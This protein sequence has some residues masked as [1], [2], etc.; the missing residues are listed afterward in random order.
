MTWPSSEPY[1]KRRRL[2][3]S[4]YLGKRTSTSPPTNELRTSSG[5]Q[6]LHYQRHG[7]TQTNKST[8]VGRRGLV[9]RS[10]PLDHLSLVPEGHPE[11]ANEHWMTSSMPNAHT[12]RIC[13]TPSETVEISST[14]L[15]MANPSN[16]YHLPHHEE[17]LENLDNLNNRKG[18][19]VERSRTS[20]ERSTS[21][22]GDMGRKKARGSRNSTIDRYW[23]QPPVSLPPIGGPN[24][25]SP[26]L[27]WI[28]GSTLII[29]ANTHSSSIR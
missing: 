23:W 21:S 1:C 14:P 8:S 2:P 6:N 3:S 11:E 28:N 18:E 29:Q 26:L 12:T 4:S 10:T 5:E 20:M 16:L 9:K 15:G 7:V 13:A 19:E 17:G 24:T 25:R 27:E 22:S